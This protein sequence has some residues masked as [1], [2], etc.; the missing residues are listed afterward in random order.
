MDY[1]VGSKAILKFGD[2]DGRLMLGAERYSI[3]NSHVSI[4]L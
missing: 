1:W 2:V 3:H 4:R